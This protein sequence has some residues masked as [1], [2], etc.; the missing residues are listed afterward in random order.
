VVVA[1]LDFNVPDILRPR[2]KII[3]FTPLI[4]LT[5]IKQPFFTK[6]FLLSSV[7]PS[8]KNNIPRKRVV[9]LLNFNYLISRFGNGQRLVGVA[10]FHAANR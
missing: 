4:N 8:V 9:I 6:P 1:Q 5:E 10:G 7:S 2:K 3:A